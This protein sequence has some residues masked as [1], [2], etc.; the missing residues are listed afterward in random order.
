MFVKEVSKGIEILMA[1]ETGSFVRMSDQIRL[2]DVCSKI[3]DV[4][5]VSFTDI[6][7]LILAWLFYF[8]NKI[9]HYGL[10]I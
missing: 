2:H 4:Y 6:N 3:L 10:M 8:E 9:E 1:E 5:F 7:S